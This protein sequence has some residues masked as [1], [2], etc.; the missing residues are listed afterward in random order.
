MK[1][2][3]CPYCGEL[4]SDHC[5]CEREAAEERE[6]MIEEQEERQHQSGFY[7]FQDLMEMWRNER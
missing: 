3:Y 5:D 4:L 7:A 6:R 1:K 2:L